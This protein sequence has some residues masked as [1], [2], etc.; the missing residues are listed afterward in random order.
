MGI[1]IREIFIS[2]DNQALDF[3]IFISVSARMF[4]FKI[5]GFTCLALKSRSKFLVLNRS[6]QQEG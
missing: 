4:E 6:V 1:R 5:R 3:Q 2:N